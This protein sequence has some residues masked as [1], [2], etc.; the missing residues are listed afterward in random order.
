MADVKYLEPKSITRTAEKITAAGGQKIHL[1]QKG[2]AKIPTTGSTLTLTNAY[3]AQGLD[4]GLISVPQL[5]KRGVNVYLTKE[6]AYLEK[7]DAKIHLRQLG[8]L[9][10]L[11]MK[12]NNEVVALLT[13]NKEKVSAETWH[14]RL[15]HVSNEKMKQLTKHKMVPDVAAQYDANQCEICLSMKPLRK[16]IANA[17]EISG[18]TVVKVD[19]MPM[20]QNP[21]GWKGEVGAYVYSCRISKIL[22][23]YPV[24][25]ATAQEAAESLEDYLMNVAQYLRIK[26]TCI[27][28]DAGSQF[29]AKG[30]TSVCASHGLKSRSCP[31][32][33]QE[34]NGQVERMIGILAAKVR[35]LLGTMEV[36][37]KYWP[38]A[39]VTAAYL[40]NRTPSVALGGRAPLEAGTG[41]KP[42]LSRMKVFGCKAFVQIPK[43]Q[44]K[45]KLA[46]IAW[47]GMMV[48]YSTNSPEWVVLNRRTNYLR[49]AYSVTFLENVKGVGRNS[50]NEVKTDGYKG[51]MPYG[52][53]EHDNGGSPHNNVDTPEMMQHGVEQKGAQPGTPSPKSPANSPTDGSSL[54]ERSDSSW[55]GNDDGETNDQTDLCPRRTARIRRQFNPNYMPS[56]TMEI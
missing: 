50:D 16:P 53:V 30:W 24:E 39:I 43:P 19:Y 9:W 21:R 36:P 46:P 2:T 38:L 40:L 44:R 10:A 37:S 32:D 54:D 11:P 3:Y 12:Q 28:T 31:V 41:E 56:G 13:Q 29:A 35:S 7:N 1:T 17:A 47:Q 15:G 5:V 25:N 14:R 34:M 18:E 52:I 8:D 49:K 45:G 55:E 4:F 26:I 33:H 22:K 27:Q 23:V 48:G 51:L 20:G 6:Q 42:N